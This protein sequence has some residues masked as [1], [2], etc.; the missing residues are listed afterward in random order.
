VIYSKSDP[1]WVEENTVRVAEYFYKKYEKK[2]IALLSDGQIVDVSKVE[3]LPDQPVEPTELEPNPL[4]IVNKRTARVP[5]VKWC[6]MNGV[7]ILEKQ[8]WPGKYIPI[9]PVYGQEIMLDGKRVFEGIVR[10]AKDP[11]RMYDYWA[12][13]ETEAIA[14]APKAPFIVAE[15][16]VED[17]EGDWE[18][19]NQ[20]AH[21][22]LKYKPTSLNGQP[23]PPPQRNAFEPA[24]QSITQAR[25]MAS[26]DMKATTGIYDASLGARSNETSGVA[27]Q[28]RNQQAQTS[29]FHFVDN[30]T[31]SIRHT[32][33]III[34]L[35]PHIYD[36]ARA[37]RIIG[38]EGDQRVVR[39]NEN[40][41]DK[42]KDVLYDMKAGKYDVTVEV[43]PSFSSRRQE[44][45]MFM[46]EMVR[47]YPPTMD[48][49]GDLVLKY[50]DIPGAMELSE[51]FKKTLPPGLADGDENEQPI[52][53]HVQARMQQMQQMIEQMTAKLNELQD[54]REKKLLE[55][56]S[57]E[58]I[59]LK[60][61]E[62][63][64]E[65][66]LAKIDAR[67]AITVLNQEIAQINQRMALL[68]VDQPIV[69]NNQVSPT[70]SLTDSPTGPQAD[71]TM[72]LPGGPGDGSG[73]A[74]VAPIPT[75]GVTPGTSL[76]GLP[77][78]DD[79]G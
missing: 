33:R 48:K 30:L 45:A 47:A 16:Q 51:R 27:I 71:P 3:H 79:Q 43:G 54:E 78:N 17:Y 21:S 6:K 1:V 65:I 40:T 35:I 32:G 68:R 61:L 69:K 10:H 34:D 67:D 50:S 13:A 38:D 64:A 76:E 42:G 18:T 7:E 59:E 11:A 37:Q 29:N 19:A 57:K 26:E 28:R 66:E 52:P 41:K 14:L 46:Q 20:R 12:S 25:A 15:G 75:G 36:A 77:T 31:R 8:D 62:T 5:V 74:G 23:V 9:V 72:D 44:A 39:I 63:N 60:K 73:M 49:A 53:Q 22:I 24:V 4:Y 70:P 55:L 56:E 2:Q 58:R